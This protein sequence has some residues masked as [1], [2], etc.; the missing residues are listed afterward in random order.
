MAKLSIHNTHL[1]F[2]TYLN[3]T[4]FRSL[5]KSFNTMKPISMN[6][7]ES[8][9]THD[10]SVPLAFTRK[11]GSRPIFFPIVRKLMRVR[12]IDTTFD[13]LMFTTLFPRG[14]LL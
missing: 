5:T 4:T 8:Q 7:T 13:I 14:P 3:T 1:P 11:G 10:G 9:A 2:T 6:N 12:P